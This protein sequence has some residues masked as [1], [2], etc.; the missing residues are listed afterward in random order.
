MTQL[1]LTNNYNLQ[2]LY[3]ILLKPMMQSSEAWKE[4]ASNIEKLA[5]CLRDYYEILKKKSAE[6]QENRSQMSPVRTVSKNCTVEHRKRVTAVPNQ[7]KS[8]DSAVRRLGTGDE[9]YLFFDEEI[10]IESHF[11]NRMQRYR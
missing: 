4:A 6:M 5:E 8:L 9:K 11:D 10:H 2:A 3:S 7:Y 1:H